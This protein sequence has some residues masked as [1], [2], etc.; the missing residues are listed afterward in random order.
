MS[1]NPRSVFKTQLESLRTSTI[2]NIQVGLPNEINDGLDVYQRLLEEL[3]TSFND[4]ELVGPRP[5]FNLTIFGPTSGEQLGWLHSDYSDFFRQSLRSGDSVVIV[6]VLNG[7]MGIVATCIQMGNLPD[8]DLFLQLLTAVWSD[9][10]KELDE[11]NWLSVRA[12]IVGILNTSSRLLMSRRR[13]MATDGGNV[14]ER[15]STLMASVAKTFGNMMKQC[16]DAASVSDFI[17]LADAIGGTSENLTQLLHGTKPDMFTEQSLQY[18]SAATVGVGGWML[19][20]RS[21]AALA[22]ETFFELWT[23]YMSTIQQSWET[24]TIVNSFQW[25]GF[26]GWSSWEAF[27]V[28]PNNGFVVSIAGYVEDALMIGAANLQQLPRPDDFIQGDDGPRSARE[29]QSMVDHLLSRLDDA[30]DNQARTDLLAP[31]NGLDAIRN[32]LDAI[33]RDYSRQ[34]ENDLIKK[35]LD[36]D[37]VSEFFEAVEKEWDAQQKIV[38][39]LPSERWQLEP[40]T[41]HPSEVNLSW[42]ILGPYV[43]ISKD[44]FAETHVSADPKMLAFE[45]VRA[46]AQSEA[47]LL[48]TELISSLPIRKTKRTELTSAIMREVA[49]QRKNGLEP[50]VAL[51]GNYQLLHTVREKDSP[52]Q[53]WGVGFAGQISNAKIFWEHGLNNEHCIVFDPSRIGR[54]WWREM[55]ISASVEGS[56]ERDGRRIIEVRPIDEA[57]AVKLSKQQSTSD[58]LDLTPE[59]DKTRELLQQ[60]LVRFQ[61]IVLVE[62]FEDHGV[63]FEITNEPH[64]E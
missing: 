46:L 34:L 44:F 32:S 58:E 25:R 4:L 57:T 45:V 43:T 15:N 37:R 42:R 17:S 53:V 12:S 48:R 30:G 9:S 47:A 28:G 16:V 36:S 27:Y 52:G 19:Y 60:V 24:L 2:R 31:G 38:D 62:I 56:V 39:L 10:K 26:F 14:M 22:S 59:K 64:V 51:F 5:V 18:L 35:D 7:L 11:G 61:E 8:L 41:E 55:E 23:K 1:N 63:A 20:L 3:L 13:M 33:R 40:S 50:I 54:V 21:R 49:R 6:S 29:I